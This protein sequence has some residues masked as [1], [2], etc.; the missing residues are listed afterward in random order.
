MSVDDPL[1]LT[2]SKMRK[3]LKLEHWHK[4]ISRNFYTFSLLSLN[5]LMFCVEMLM[6]GC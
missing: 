1:Y 2:L 3:T 6:K 5:V 4:I